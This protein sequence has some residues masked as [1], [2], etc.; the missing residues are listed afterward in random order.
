LISLLLLI[1]LHTGARLPAQ[2]AAAADCDEWQACRA[3][4]LEARERGD[5]ERFHD[6]AWRAMQTRGRRDPELMFLLSR[7]Q[8][9]SGRP[10][11]ALVMLRRLAE[12]GEAFDALTHE[13]L[14]RTRSL[15]GWRETEALLVKAP[16]ATAE[17]P[18]PA[19]SPP[20]P[21][22]SPA[23]APAGKTARAGSSVT[24]R[25]VARFPLAAADF[26]GLA[27][28]AVSKR[29][30]VGNVPAR[31]LTVI[32]EGT[33]RPA[34]YA[35]A[36]AALFDVRALRI[37]RREGD[38]WVVSTDCSPPANCRS[39]LHKLQ[40]ISGR[41]LKVFDPPEDTSRL[42]D[43][44]VAGG[45]VLALDADGP[46]LLRLDR[47]SGKMTRTASLPEGE[48]TTF[49]IPA[50]GSV[51]Y[52]AYRDRLVRVET[53]TGKAARVR[54]RGA[55][56]TGVERMRWH[57]GALVAIQ[58]DGPASSRRIV[59]IRLGRGGAQAQAVDVLSD[60]DDDGGRVLAMDVAGDEVYYLVAPAT[61]EG[62]TAIRTATLK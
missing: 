31:K 57:R 52:V 16:A 13:D 42:L 4:A 7:A 39:A 2:I 34:T 51:A 33:N 10:H 23:K 49:A 54:H 36:A 25:T 17:A 58:A 40:L 35:G 28:D 44:A 45:S 14:A 61:T 19:A 20:H 15:P 12:L 29:F 62:E 60:V 22:G 11:D 9:L 37:D 47:A 53:R 1:V 30:I 41:V 6:L 38:L 18:E 32:G 50:D 55:D 48:V 5:F 43:V 46:R 27:Y 3:L 26:G 8:S 59:R 24:A 21:E 56:L